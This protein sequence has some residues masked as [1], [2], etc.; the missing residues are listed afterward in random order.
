MVSLTALVL[1]I[2]MVVVQLAMGQFSPRIVQ[3]ILRDK[4][5]QPPDR[6]LVEP[7]AVLIACNVWL[8]GTGQSVR[9]IMT[10]R[11]RRSCLRRPVALPRPEG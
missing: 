7:S 9:R 5:S 3:R 6:T 10:C 1:T 4:P 11:L 8:V 2:T